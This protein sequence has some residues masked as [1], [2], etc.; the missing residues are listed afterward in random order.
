MGW[1]APDQRA[2]DVVYKLRPMPAVVRTF[3]EADAMPDTHDET[4]R[5]I[6]LYGPHWHKGVVGIVASRI[7]ERYHKPAILLTHSDGL[8]VGSA[9]SATHRS[10]PR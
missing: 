2:V 7:V 5:S 6:V 1:P 4:R 8:A 9:R 3:E 10:P